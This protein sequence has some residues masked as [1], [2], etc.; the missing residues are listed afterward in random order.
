MKC[1]YNNYHRAVCCY[2][3]FNSNCLAMAMAPNPPDRFPNAGG[4]M[5]SWILSVSKGNSI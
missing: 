1:S 3:K 5:Y 2:V 4:S